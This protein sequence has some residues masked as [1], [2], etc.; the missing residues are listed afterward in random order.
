MSA[1]KD[2]KGPGN[3]AVT[4]A[5]ATTTSAFDR[6]MTDNQVTEAEKTAMAARLNPVLGFGELGLWAPLRRPSPLNGTTPS[7]VYIHRDAPYILARLRGYPR[8][9]PDDGIEDGVLS[10]PSSAL[11]SESKAETSA[12]FEPLHPIFHVCTLFES[13][14]HGAADGKVVRFESSASR[15]RVTELLPRLAIHADKS[16]LA[17]SDPSTKR[18]GSFSLLYDELFARAFLDE[19]TGRPTGLLD[20][21][22]DANGDKGHGRLYPYVPAPVLDPALISVCFFRPAAVSAAGLATQL[23]DAR[24]QLRRA[25]ARVQNASLAST[26]DRH[27]VRHWT[28][29][30]DHLYLLWQHARSVEFM[31]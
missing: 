19:K 16:L 12:M 8:Q 7:D 25:E 20:P 10:A 27:R 23:E 18:F 14:A 4:V 2:V 29:R 6:F 21:W 1:E 31:Q 26:V 30:V 11:S 13:E 24:V 5:T 22:V 17:E 28:E 15:L 3:G 9:W